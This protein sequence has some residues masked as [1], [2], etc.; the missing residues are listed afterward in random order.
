MTKVNRQIT[1]LASAGN[2]Q[3]IQLYFMYVG[4]G[5]MSDTVSCLQKHHSNVG[6]LPTWSRLMTASACMLRDTDKMYFFRLAHSAFLCLH[7]LFK[8]ITLKHAAV[9]CCIT[10]Q[11]PFYGECPK[12]NSNS[13]D[14]FGIAAV[15]AIQCCRA[16][17]VVVVVLEPGKN[18]LSNFPLCR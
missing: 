4:H 10:P 14:A 18:F 13:N 6:V 3:Y 17:I 9:L 7:A 12:K 5:F 16:M 8:H 1:R 11:L 2:I 15:S